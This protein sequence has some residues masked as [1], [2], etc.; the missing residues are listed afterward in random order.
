MKKNQILRGIAM[1]AASAVTLGS[2]PVSASA[3][4]NT[5]EENLL[6]SFDFNTDPIFDSWEVKKRLYSQ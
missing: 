4:T 1:L 3:D 5:S 2:L 6:A